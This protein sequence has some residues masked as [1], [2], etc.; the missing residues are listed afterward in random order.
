MAFVKGSL[1]LSSQPGREEDDVKGAHTNWTV[2][3]AVRGLITQF[4]ANGLK[5]VTFHAVPD[6]DDD[7]AARMLAKGYSAT[8]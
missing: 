5:V 4:C 6:P 3:L 8:V 1:P 2:G 7:G